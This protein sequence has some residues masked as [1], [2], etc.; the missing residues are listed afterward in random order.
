MF[1]RL[2]VLGVVV[3][4]ALT[5]PGAPHAQTPAT[6]HRAWTGTWE[7]HDTWAGSGRVGRSQAQITYHYVQAP[8]AF[9]GL[10]W[11]SR[12]LTWR[13]VWE[14][15]RFDYVALWEHPP[16]ERGFTMRRYREDSV[17]TCTSGGTL[18]L[19]PAVAGSGD[20]L[21]PAQKAQLL[22]SCVTT[23]QPREGGVP[24]PPPSTTEAR[25]LVQVL[26]M[27]NEEELTGCTYEKAWP[28]GGRPAGSFSVSVSASL[29]AVMEVSRRA[30][31]DYARFV[32]TP[33][34]TLTFTAS[35][36]SG[37]ARFRFELDP[38]ATSRF[39][40]YATNAN[41]DD[42][43]FVKYSLSSQRRDY[44]NDG[45]D[46]IFDRSHFEN[47]QEW[48][49]VEPLVV[50]T[51]GPRRAAVVTVTAM[52]YGAV[53]RLRAF[54]R[55][56][57]CGDWQPVPITFYP[58]TREF[59]A[60]PMDEDNNLMADAVEEY[61][62]RQSGADDDAEPKGNGQAGDGLTVFEE[63]RGF[64]TSC[65]ECV[66]RN[67]DSHVRTKPTVKDLFVHTPDPEL[68]MTLPHFAWSSGVETHAICEAQYSGNPQIDWESA[69]GQQAGDLGTRPAGRKRIVNFTLQLARL[70]SWQGHVLTQEV[71]QH[72][73]YLVNRETPEGLAG[74]TCMEDPPFCT[75]TRL[76][77][78]MLTS[79]AI[80]DK[81]VVTDQRDGRTG[82]VSTPTHELGHAVGL[83]HHGWRIENGSGVL[84]RWNKHFFA[85][86]PSVIPPGPDC[87]DPRQQPA[88]NVIGV[89]YQGTFIGCGVITII[90]RN[91]EHSGRADCPMRY[92]FGEVREAP[93]PASVGY[94]V[95]RADGSVTG[96]SGE[97]K[98]WRDRFGDARRVRLWQ[99][100][101]LKYDNGLDHDALGR[102]CPVNAG[103]G[104]NG[105]PGDQNHAGDSQVA[106][107]DQLVINDNV[108][109]GTR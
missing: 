105:L 54:V 45:P 82:R 39:P 9:G 14:E 81:A 75:G 57:E 12:R 23:Y 1:R 30:E 68:E 107:M 108:L 63:Y 18:E 15:N 71:P 51:A 86:E 73:I 32:P 44:K 89:Y 33:G 96:S 50:E 106:C 17:T 13:A 66:Y 52:D 56:D 49:R 22:A 41:I 36:P 80:V 40:G 99:G 67:F 98:P 77:P 109:R 60:I 93:G 6:T 10:A 88:D 92:S 53:G 24:T 61:H 21:T 85:E 34:A 20:D 48:S 94:E 43:F 78:P 79:V 46:V 83:P 69:S 19:G 102:F 42:A 72:G 3:V 101:F 8:D 59:I 104:L 29:G 4:A 25:E 70:Y 2:N 28:K 97:I 26:G 11:A 74:V 84:V 103:T 27:P 87:V 58:D 65:G 47:R 95:V 100:R 31:E 16:D 55:S 35:V 76:G 64:L 7:E 5:S 91:G 90:A 37:T 38:D 62:G